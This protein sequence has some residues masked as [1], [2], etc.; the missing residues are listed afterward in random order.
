MGVDFLNWHLIWIGSN[1]LLMSSN[2]DKH[3]CVVLSLRATDSCQDQLLRDDGA[4]T[5]DL[6]VLVA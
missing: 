4:T 1:E 6:S 3:V 2:V 5:C